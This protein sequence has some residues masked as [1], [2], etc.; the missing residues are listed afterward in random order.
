M[1]NDNVTPAIAW[2][3]TKDEIETDPDG[4]IVFDDTVLGKNHSHKMDFVRLQYSGNAHDL[5]EGIGVINCLHVNPRTQ[6]YWI[7]DWRVYTPDIDGKSK[8]THMREMF[9]DALTI[10]K[11]PFR[12]VLIDSWYATK[13][14]ML[15]LHRAGKVFYCPLKSNRKVDDSGCERA[16]QAVSEL[17]WDGQDAARGKLIKIHGFP[18]ALKVKLFRIA[19]TTCRI[20][21]DHMVS[22][23]TDA[24]AP[25]TTPS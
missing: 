21:D 15:H 9:D 22:C 5:I 24:G 2:G 6:R 11:L 17:T 10:K 4:C 13:D 25:G 14:I 16:Y 7:I 19:M 20:P 8:L 23:E 18:G 1:H 3:Q 12:A